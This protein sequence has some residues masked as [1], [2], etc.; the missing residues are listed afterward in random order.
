MN[1]TI[2][3]YIVLILIIS[4]QSIVGVGVLV[5][6]TPIMLLLN[7]SMVEVLSIL[8]P[9]SIVT[10]LGNFLYFKF[11]KKKM[12]I[13]IDSEIKKYLMT[14][15]IPSIFIGL[16]ILKHFENYINLNI[17][18]SIMIILS[19]LFL[20][21]FK[22]KVFT[23]NK[24]FKIIAL[25]LIGITHGITNSGG[26]M[27]SIF[28]TALQKNKINESR[29]NITFAY[30]FLGFFQDAIFILIFKI[31]YYNFE[32]GTIFIIILFG[33]ILG[34]L[35]IK[36]INEHIFRIIINILALISAF[37]LIMRI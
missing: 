36:F 21:K 1:E 11:Q 35:L 15:C 4:L 23:W 32:L 25:G 2:F 19:I 29:Y 26:T 22:D 9:I 5:L 14:I 16:L 34:N 20:I 28:V 12:N 17:V 13:K 31:D 37:L 27:L 8:L 7:Y 18:V 10:S 33:I 24:K 6:G 30:L 3:T